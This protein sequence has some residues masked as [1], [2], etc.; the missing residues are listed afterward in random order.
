MLDRSDGSLAELIIHELTHGTIFVRNDV[1]F[2][3]NLATFIGTEGAKMFLKDKFGTSS[4]KLDNY[5]T[6]VQD[7]EKFSDYVLSG[8]DLLR[9]LYD[10]IEPEWPEYK[11]EEEK[12]TWFRSFKDHLDTVEFNNDVHYRNYLQSREL[13]NTFFMSYLRYRGGQEQFEKTFSGQ[14]NGD[15]PQYIKYLKAEYD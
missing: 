11:K 13:N 7:R 4:D 5:I 14:F 2:N 10:S 12:S 6:I 9:Q 8:A 3:E 15:L 1:S